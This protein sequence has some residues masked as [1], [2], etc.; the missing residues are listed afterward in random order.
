MLLKWRRDRPRRL[1]YMSKYP[2]AYSL[3]TCPSISTLTF[4]SLNLLLSIMKEESFDLRDARIR[5]RD[6]EFRNETWS[7]RRPLL[8]PRFEI[9][10]L[11]I[12]LTVW[13]ARQPV[14]PDRNELARMGKDGICSATSMYSYARRYTLLID[15]IT[16]F[17]FC[18]SL[19]SSFRKRNGLHPK[20]WLSLTIKP[21]WY[22]AKSLTQMQH[23]LNL[24]ALE[25][26]HPSADSGSKVLPK[27]Q[28]PRR[29]L[30]ET[31]PPCIS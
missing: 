29:C 24:N 31:I 25:L 21:R 11:T 28:H 3:I 23:P 19:G 5:T 30:W 12:L 1:S 27:V 10:I 4:N 6:L 15:D 14:H 17:L 26:L 16:R 13:R 7:V 20:A 22:E 2:G 8:A 18:L 9:P